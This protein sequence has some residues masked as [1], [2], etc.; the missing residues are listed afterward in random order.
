MRREDEFGRPRVP[1]YDSGAAVN[2]P[3]TLTAQV[4]NQLES[5]T[6]G[7]SKVS[8]LDRQR[9]SLMFRARSYMAF[10]L[11]PQPPVMDW[12]ADLDSSLARSRGFFA[13]HPVALDLSAV[14][15]SAS[16]IAQLVLG[17]EERGMRVLGIEG[18]D[19]AAA[20]AGLPP[21]LRTSRGDRDIEIP[22][23]SSAAAP[24]SQAQP[25][26]P[27]QPQGPASL[28]LDN[29]VRSGQSVVF[30]DGDITVLGSVGSGAEIVAGGS[31]HVYGTLRGRA[32]A[33]A[34]GDARARIFCHRVEAEL[35]AIA[36]YYKT[37]EEI[38]DSLR[39]QAAQAWLEGKTLRISA[40]N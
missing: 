39:R 27:P 9:Q 3:L 40:M 37:A 14:Q 15:L 4:V 24:A 35:L 1:F 10:A 2:R 30:L 16:A 25:M 6:T 34:S 18:L 31:I 11:T 20:P 21:L 13:G 17:L 26:P 33:G 22:E 29:P 36:S 7:E 12:L 23:P 5:T 28:L 8:G 19:P 32:M 38:D